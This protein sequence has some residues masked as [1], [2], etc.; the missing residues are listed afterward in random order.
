M[1][2]CGA[3]GING[4]HSLQFCRTIT[5][6]FTVASTDKNVV[7]SRSRYIFRNPETNKNR[8]FEE[9][10]END[11]PPP[12]ESSAASKRKSKQKSLTSKFTSKLYFVD[13]AGSKR[14]IEQKK[15]SLLSALGNVICALG[16]ESRKVT[17]IPYRDSKL[18]RLLQEVTVKL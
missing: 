13:L 2:I 6:R 4:R 18:T 3:S 12:A 10:K 9:N 1:S 15:E 5:K 16:D 14:V 11:A 17:H 7:S 8:K